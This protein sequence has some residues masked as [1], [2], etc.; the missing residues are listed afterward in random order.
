MVVPRAFRNLNLPDF[1]RPEAKHQLS[2]NGSSRKIWRMPLKTQLAWCGLAR[3]VLLACACSG[4]VPLRFNT[5]PGASGVVVD[6]E[7]HAPLPGAEVVV[8]QLIYPPPSADEAFINSRP[9]VVM[10][11]ASGHF[12]IPPQRRW[13]FFVVPIDVF[14]RFGLLVVKC[15]GY[16]SATVPFWSR[17]V[18]N[19]GDIA[20]K[21]AKQ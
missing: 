14:P 15:E 5:S 20:L 18:Q 17:A 19:V 16:T 3:T 11:D 7:R 8:S 1:I 6:A 9:P 4:C 12:T 10:T 13:D 2:A 21:P